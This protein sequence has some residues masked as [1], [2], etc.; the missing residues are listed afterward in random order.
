[1]ISDR[2]DDEHMV[3]CKCNDLKPFVKRKI[4]EVVEVHEEMTISNI[5]C[6]KNQ[7]L[8]FVQPLNFWFKTL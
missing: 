4:V 8:R 5:L 7:C 6:L 1:M 3:L 2:D